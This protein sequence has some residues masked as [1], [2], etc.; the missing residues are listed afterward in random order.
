MSNEEESFHWCEKTAVKKRDGKERL[1]IVSGV[2]CVVD[3]ADSKVVPV[4]SRSAWTGAGVH[5]Q[6]RDRAMPGHG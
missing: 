2:C 6:D 1:L 3:L 5:E 4:L